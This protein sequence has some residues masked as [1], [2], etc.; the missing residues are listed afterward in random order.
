MPDDGRRAALRG[1][2]KVR[3]ARLQP[4]D[5]GLLS[6][7]RR[8]AEGLRRDEVAALAGVSVT[9]YTWLETAHPKKRFSLKFVAS[10]ARALQLSAGD[11]AELFS[12]AFPEFGFAGALPDGTGVVERL[13][14]DTADATCYGEVEDAA[15]CSLIELLRPAGPGFILSQG[16]PMWTFTRVMGARGSALHGH[17]VPQAAPGPLDLL[18]GRVSRIRYPL[19]RH[20]GAELGAILNAPL[21]CAKIF[22][23]AIGVVDVFSRKF[24]NADES[25]AAAV[26]AI[27]AQARVRFSE[28]FA[29]V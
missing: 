2:L 20:D 25:L 22:L 21:H 1:F 19:G 15:L 24:S 17:R 4:A 13:A 18:A 8:R 10:V 5:V 23:G 9:W 12:L 11:T 7:G 6:I 14:R 26:A 3:R 16:R 28:P 29:N 27:L